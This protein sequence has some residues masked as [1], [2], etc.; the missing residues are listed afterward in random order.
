[1][2]SAITPVQPVWW[3]AP[4]PAPLSPWKY[5]LKTRLSF[6]AGSCC[7]RSHAAE[8]RPATVGTAEEQAR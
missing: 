6:H 4:R 5:S 7:S 2:T 3:D 8:A 1:M